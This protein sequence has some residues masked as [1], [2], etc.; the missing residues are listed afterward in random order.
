MARLQIKLSQKESL[1]L[2]GIFE[3]IKKMPALKYFIVSGLSAEETVDF[4]C[5]IIEIRVS[6]NDIL[7]VPAP[8]QVF[9]PFRVCK[10]GTLKLEPEPLRL[11]IEP[12]GD[13]YGEKVYKFCT[14]ISVIDCDHKI[15]NVFETPFET[16][17]NFFK[18]C[19]CSDWKEH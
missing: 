13:D 16:Y 7:V 6:D 18:L 8:S 2:S 5:K 10:S 1:D 4:A 19:P 9:E 12:Q 3:A 17:D 15:G 11:L 14:G